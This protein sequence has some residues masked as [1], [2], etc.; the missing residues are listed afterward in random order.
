MA[1]A[2]RRS[3]VAIAI[4][5]VAVYVHVQVLL[6]AL[7]LHPPLVGWI[8]LMV[9]T[10]AAAALS[11]AAAVIFPRL[12]TNADP[13]RARDS[14]VYRLLVVSDV[15]A[16]PEALHLAVTSR[17]AG[18]PSEVHVVAPVVTGALHFVT[19]DEHAER[20]R[21]AARLRATLEVLAA[22]GIPAKVALGSDDPLGAAADAL[23]GFRADEILF[24]GALE[25]RRGWSDRDFER[26]ARDVLGLPCA[27]VY[28]DP[29]P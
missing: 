12:R 5:L 9:V 8:G 23:V 15:I 3:P 17:T 7:Y 26:Q 29:G 11:V 14:G 1:R 10:A 22:S 27:T 21:A 6:A 20:V 2:G 24:V 4:A 18:R 16:E 25:H 28:G 13:V 19:E